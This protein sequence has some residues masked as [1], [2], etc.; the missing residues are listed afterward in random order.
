MFTVATSPLTVNF[1]TAGTWLGD[2]ANILKAVQDGIGIGR[3]ASG[4]G[5]KFDFGS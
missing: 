1:G 5:F 2:V 4:A 3:A